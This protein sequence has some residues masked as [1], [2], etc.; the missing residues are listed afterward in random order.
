MKNQILTGER[1]ESRGKGSLLCCLCGLLFVSGCTT[2]KNLVN[3]VKALAKD[4]A[5]VRISY[6]PLIFERFVPQP[7]QP[8]GYVPM[9]AQW[10]TPYLMPQPGLFWT[11][12]TTNFFP[13]PPRSER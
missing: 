1:R 6:G 3:L 12:T 2:Q 13:L 7:Q 9:P 10:G 4:P 5:T 8:G 11:P